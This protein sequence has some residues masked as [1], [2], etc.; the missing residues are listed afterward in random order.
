MEHHIH[1]VRHVHVHLGDAVATGMLTDLPK[2][3]VAL[4]AQIRAI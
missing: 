3:K 4:G 2:R 1:S